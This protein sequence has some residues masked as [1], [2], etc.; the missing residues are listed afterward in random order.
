MSSKHKEIPTIGF[1]FIRYLSGVPGVKELERENESN[2][3]P[4]TIPLGATF[5]G[6]IFYKAYVRQNLYIAGS[7]FVNSIFCCCLG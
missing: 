2:S 6:R 3:G 7:F 1:P 4:I 5:A